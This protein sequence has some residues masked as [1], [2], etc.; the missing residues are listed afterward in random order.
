MRDVKNSYKILVGNIQGKR[1]YTRPRSRQ[2]KYIKLNLKE[3]RCGWSGLDLT[4]SG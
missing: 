4:G 3:M 2:K 1:E